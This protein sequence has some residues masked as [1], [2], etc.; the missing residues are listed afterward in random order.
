MNYRRTNP[1]AISTQ[2]DT[3]N[4]PASWKRP[5]APSLLRM[6]C[7]LRMTCFIACAWIPKYFISVWSAFWKSHTWSVHYECLG[8]WLFS[9]N[10]V[11]RRFA[12]TVTCAF[13]VIRVDYEKHPMFVYA[14]DL[15]TLHLLNTWAVLNLVRWE[16]TPL[17]IFLPMST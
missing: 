4:L 14:T 6:T 8:V 13:Y 2:V 10:T 11:H 17:C 16:I 15:S 5:R 9:P 1:T 3:Q 12:H 7:S